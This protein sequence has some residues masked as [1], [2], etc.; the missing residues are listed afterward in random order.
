MKPY[1]KFINE[2]YVNLFNKFLKMVLTPKMNAALGGGKIK[3]WLS[4]ID[5]QP[6]RSEFND[7]PTEE[8]TGPQAT[9]HFYIN[10]YP[11]LNLDAKESVI[12][13]PLYNFGNNVLG[14]NYENFFNYDYRNETFK[15]DVRINKTP[16]HELT[17]QV[18][19]SLTEGVGPSDRVI[20]NICDAEK[21]CKTQGKITFG[22]LKSLVENAKVKKLLTD[23]GEGG[24]KATLRLLPWFLPQL[25]VAGFTGSMVR[26]FNKIFRPAIE[27][28]TSYKTWW[29]K[30][31][32]RIFNLVEGE[33]GITDPLSKIFF[34]SDGL[35]TMLDNKEKIK[36]ARYIAE[37]ATEK[38]NNE[39]VPEYFV[40]NELRNWLN[41]K[42]LLD[43]P[44]QP[45]EVK[46]DN[47][48]PEVEINENTKFNYEDS[49]EYYEKIDKL[50]TKF[51][52]TFKIKGNPNFL[53]FKVISGKNRYGDFTV[54]LTGVFKEPFSEEDSN[55]SHKMSRNVIKIIKNTFPFLT[56]ATF[57]G[58]STS[59]LA[60]YGSNINFEKRYL[61]R[62]VEI[63]K[64]PF[65]EEIT[66]GVRKRVFSESV[67]DEELKW[68]FDE[69]DRKVK[70]VKSN[71]WS[72]QM[73]N[74]LPTQLN[75][76]DVITIPKG[77]YHRVIKGSGDLIVKIKEY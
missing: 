26:A 52:S 38:P 35:L 17:Y 40:E 70:V 75:E 43:P 57:H 10:T 46:T 14:L 8:L 62:S 3:F 11:K 50:L 37:L 49:E 63:P 58:G 30:T 41:Q 56:T 9:V 54:K 2:K 13:F 15:A 65:Q 20:K 25:A 53:G 23:V 69:K 48:S 72:L 5:I 39:E 76:G 61:N 66:K 6:K 33:L 32:M 55:I 64:L 59:T 74:G 51:L 19:D 16:K 31:I 44:L 24:Y 36:F 45:K 73:D 47:N 1:D 12:I 28:T 4:G 22:Q 29:G 7:I 21:F 27:D 71:G 42:F 68:H 34:I 60:S 18:E 67:G 77:V